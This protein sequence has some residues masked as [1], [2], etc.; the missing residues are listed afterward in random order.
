MPRLRHEEEREGRPLA[1]AGKRWFCSDVAGRAWR[2][3]ILADW[4]V[5][6]D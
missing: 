4:K 6:L 2:A 1:A 3:E 5:L